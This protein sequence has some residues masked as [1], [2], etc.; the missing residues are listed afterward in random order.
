MIPPVVA[1]GGEMEMVRDFTYSGSK[2]SND[3]E[4]T[5]L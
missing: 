1:E 4:V 2:L 3:G 5:W